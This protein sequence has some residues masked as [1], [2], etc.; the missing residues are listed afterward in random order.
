[1]SKINIIPIL[2]FIISALTYFVSMFVAGDLFPGSVMIIL[3]IIL[4]IIGLVLAF[5]SKKVVK[6]VGI[7]GNLLVLFVAGIIPAISM[8]FWNSP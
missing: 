2:I 6:V 3:T 5:K 7:I 8:F 1:M 4:P